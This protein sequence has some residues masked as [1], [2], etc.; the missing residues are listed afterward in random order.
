MKKGGGLMKI[1]KL[2]SMIIISLLS[3]LLFTGCSNNNT[4]SPNTLD[5]ILEGTNNVSSDENDNENNEDYE[6]RD[7]LY[8]REGD[9][10][11][12]CE[13]LIEKSK[14]ISKLISI[15]EEIKNSIEQESGYYDEYRFEFN[16]KGE[17]KYN[18]YNT[19]PDVRNR[20]V[21]HSDGEVD[22]S[23]LYGISTE[24]LPTKREFA[25]ASAYYTNMNYVQNS[26]Y[27]EL[28][29][30][31]ISYLSTEDFTDVTKDEII[32][33]I[34]KVSSYFELRTAKYKELIDAHMKLN[35]Y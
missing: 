12:S 31:T 21:I 34:Q 29:E 1:K 11:V 20:L 7:I 8:S 35:N 17:Y 32:S 28:Y 19:V 3:I 22:D 9:V 16:A 23:E 10:Y 15:G 25:V 2:V 6:I 14:T 27:D 24:G 18:E 5:D 13:V 26:N 30:K 4:N 33:S